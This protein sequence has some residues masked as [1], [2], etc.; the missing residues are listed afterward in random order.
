MGWD[1]FYIGNRLQET[2][3]NQILRKHPFAVNHGAFDDA[4]HTLESTHREPKAATQSGFFVGTRLAEHLTALCARGAI[5]NVCLAVSYT[6][7]TLPTK[8]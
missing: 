2:K 5:S 4:I 7:L 1:W 8:A 6:H 3:P